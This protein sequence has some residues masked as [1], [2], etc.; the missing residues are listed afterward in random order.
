M[1]ARIKVPVASEWACP[2]TSAAKGVAFG[3]MAAAD[4][5]CAYAENQDLWFPGPRPPRGVPRREFEQR[6]EQAARAC[7]GCA[8][9]K[10]CF[11]GALERREAD[12]VWGGVLFGNGVSR[13]RLIQRR[14]AFVDFG[15]VRV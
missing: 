6:V 12:G 8:F 10:Q 15:E 5:V 9:A 14:A 3:G 1:R 13:N 4:P 11:S 2:S 7:G